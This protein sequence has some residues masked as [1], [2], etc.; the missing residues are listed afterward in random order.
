MSQLIKQLRAIQTHGEIKATTE[1]AANLLEKLEA[2]NTSLRAKVSLTKK[3]ELLAN[4]LSAKC[5]KLH[6]KYM[7]EQSNCMELKQKCKNKEAEVGEL[8]NE[9]DE[10]RERA[11]K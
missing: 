2:D 7:N 3:Y 11:G 6:D 4:E 10:L 5:D 9:I 1:A 8:Q